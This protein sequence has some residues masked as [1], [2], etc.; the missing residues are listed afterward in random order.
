MVCDRNDSFHVHT[1]RCGHA[2]K[3]R[4]EAYIEKAIMLGAKGIWFSDHAPFPGNPFGNRMNYEDL[5]E[6]LSTLTDLRGRYRDEIAVHIGLEIEY[7]P[8]FDRAGYYHELK[9][10]GR[11]EFLMLGQHMAE[12]PDCPGNYTFSW[13]KERLDEEEYSVLGEAIAVGIRTRHFD[14]AAHPDRIFR[15][16]REWNASM[17]EAALCIAGAAK[18]ANIPLEIN[19]HSISLKHYY[20]PQLWRIAKQAGTGTVTGLDA[21][22]VRDMERLYKGALSWI[23]KVEKRIRKKP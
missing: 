7:L 1:Y 18:K 4:D 8:S 19:M 12:D 10:D 6:Y 2:E 17:A 21:H 15:R 20:W 13:E 5:D 3:V 16:C 22:S 14:V 23:G 11:V 9:N